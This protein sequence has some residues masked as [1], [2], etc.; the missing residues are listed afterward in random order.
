MYYYHYYYG[1]SLTQRCDKKAP[2]GWGAA[3]CQGPT[4]FK[5]LGPMADTLSNELEYQAMLSA[6]ICVHRIRLAGLH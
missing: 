1:Q 3:L 2:G 5:L 6:M 4:I